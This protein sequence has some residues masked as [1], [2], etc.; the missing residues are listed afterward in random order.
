MKNKL[1]DLQHPL[2]WKV[3]IPWLVLII[4]TALAKCQIYAAVV[5][6]SW[7]YVSSSRKM[8]ASLILLA[9]G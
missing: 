1:D 5:V 2:N 6:F 8:I 9:L 7:N 4:N 3:L